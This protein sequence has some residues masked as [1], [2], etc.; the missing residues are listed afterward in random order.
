MKRTKPK[1]ISGGHRGDTINDR[2]TARQRRFVEEYLVSLNATQAAVRAGYSEKSAA[3]I[4][5]QILQ[6]NSV[7]EA[8]A[9]CF[10]ATAGERKVTGLRTIKEAENR[11]FLDPGDIFDQDGR[12]LPLGEMPRHA[13][14]CIESVEVK[15]VRG[16]RGQEPHEI[17]KIKLWPK[18]DAVDKLAKLLG[19]YRDAVQ[20]T[21]NV[22]QVHI[23][24]PEKGSIKGGDLVDGQAVAAEQPPVLDL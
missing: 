5:W 2:L 23:Y 6:K 24:L 20:Q 7:L 16:G 13:R 4:G 19:L 9:Q 11:V 8:I 10:G 1:K 3:Q 17:V 15:R 22:A 21:N 14:R 18:G 12:L